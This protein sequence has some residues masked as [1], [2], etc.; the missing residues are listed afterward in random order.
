MS[1]DLDL[2][3]LGFDKTE[4]YVYKQREMGV[5]GDRMLTVPR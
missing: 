3:E 5:M 4:V 2:E 1:E